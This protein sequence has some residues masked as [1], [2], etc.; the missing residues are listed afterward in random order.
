MYELLLNPITLLCLGIMFLLLSGLFFYF[1]RSISILERAQMDQARVLQSFITNMEMTQHIEQR[2]NMAPMN[3][4]GGSLN[5]PSSL[6]NE[7]NNNDTIDPSLI[8]VS[9]GSSDE[10]SDESD[11]ESS[12]DSDDQSSDESD[13]EKNDD[14]IDIKIN[15]SMNVI[16]DIPTQSLGQIEHIEPVDT[17]DIKVVHLQDNNTLDEMNIE[18]LN[19]TSLDN[20]STEGDDEDSDDEDSDD[21]DNGHQPEQDVNESPSLETDHIEEV[22]NF[23]SPVEHTVV[24]VVDTVSDSILEPDLK[25]LNVQALRQMAEDNGLIMKGEKKTK[26]ELLVLLDTA[27]NID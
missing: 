15:N 12:D 27:K 2:R 18:E 14:T 13:D 22:N 25:T 6:S 1:R 23:I 11:D 19:I 5:N 8:D 26:K 20:S 10:S 9:D 4:D 3:V 24:P 21:E 16:T 17:S 7:I